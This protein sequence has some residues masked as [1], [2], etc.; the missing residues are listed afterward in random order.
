MVQNSINTGIISRSAI[1]R[2][3]KG[4]Y[5]KLAAGYQKLSI[6]ETGVQS[7]FVHISNVAQCIFYDYTYSKGRTYIQ[8]SSIAR[9]TLLTDTN[10]LLIHIVLSVGGSFIL[11]T[12]RASPPE[13][14]ARGRPRKRSEVLGYLTIIYH[15][16]AS[17]P[18]KSHIITYFSTGLSISRGREIPTFPHI[19]RP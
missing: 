4:K 5:G 11:C 1:E 3:L 14:S 18:V 2:E 9:A 8:S 12:Q 17:T 13:K 19:S 15:I 7:S 10:A 16:R 6:N